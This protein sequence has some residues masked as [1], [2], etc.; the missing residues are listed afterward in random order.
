M[1]EVIG[2]RIWLTMIVSLAAVLFT[3]ALALPIGIYSA[4][5]QHS[6]WDYLFTV[7]GFA[8]LAVP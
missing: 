4:M 6:V 1:T 2:D 3:W 7:V 5:R 8:G